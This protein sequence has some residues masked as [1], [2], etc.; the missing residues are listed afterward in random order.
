M[1]ATTV[2]YRKLSLNT[3]FLYPGMLFSCSMIRLSGNGND[4]DIRN[5]LLLPVSHQPLEGLKAKEL[6]PSA[7]CL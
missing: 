4:P 2:W 1:I 5:R 6:V 7:F 3:S